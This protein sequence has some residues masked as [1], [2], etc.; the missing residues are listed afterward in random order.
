MWV[1]LHA[2]NS[3]V[4]ISDGVDT[5]THQMRFH[6]DRLLTRMAIESSQV[7]VYRLAV[8]PTCNFML[9]GR[10]DMELSY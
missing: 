10:Q 4:V 2:K 6:N 5:V 9:V 7:A 8:E 1:D 3:V